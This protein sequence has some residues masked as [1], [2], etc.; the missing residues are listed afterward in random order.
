MKGTESVK[1]LLQFEDQAQP[2][3][4]LTPERRSVSQK[5][6]VVVVVVVVCT[7]Q[8]KQNKSTLYSSKQAPI[9]RCTK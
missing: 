9:L 8:T 3:L 6:E 5:L 7:I 1:I 2:G 4:G